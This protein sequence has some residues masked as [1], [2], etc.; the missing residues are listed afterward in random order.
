MKHD[1]GWGWMQK[2]PLSSPYF[3]QMCECL[4]ATN[5]CAVFQQ[6]KAS[7]V[8]QHAARR[9][10]SV[11]PAGCCVKRTADPLLMRGQTPLRPVFPRSR[12]SQPIRGDEAM[13]H[14]ESGLHP[15]DR[16]ELPACLPA[17]LGRKTVTSMDGGVRI[18]HTTTPKYRE[19]MIYKHIIFWHNLTQKKYN[20]PLLHD[21]FMCFTL[22]F[23]RFMRQ[24]I[25]HTCCHPLITNQAPTVTL[26][27]CVKVTILP[28]STAELQYRILEYSRVQCVSL[29]ASQPLDK[30]KHCVNGLCEWELETLINYWC[31]GR[32][33]SWIHITHTQ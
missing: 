24:V 16:K 4:T 33:H 22:L 3:A 23:I 15:V 19:S 10:V 2:S 9:I 17:A 29:Q 7:P 1:C 18:L 6:A 11:H 8:L 32:S 12:K 30:Q 20:F 25:T 31:I 27:G 13:S 5:R 14:G 28:G 26:Q 21:T